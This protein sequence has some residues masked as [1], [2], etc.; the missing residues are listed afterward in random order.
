MRSLDSFSQIYLY[1]PFCDMRKGI[2]GLVS[3]VESEMHLK[4]TEAKLFAFTHKK[5]KLIKL[6][7]WNGSGFAL[8]MTKLEKQSFKWPKVG[9][10]V[11]ELE[12]REL[13][14]L[15]QGCDIMKNRP[16]QKLN[17]STFS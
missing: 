13:N 1:R 15:L 16:H 4:P 9:E 8:W 6:L 12:S 7:Y 10:D 2:N 17:Y 14:L 3:I 11:A 5:R